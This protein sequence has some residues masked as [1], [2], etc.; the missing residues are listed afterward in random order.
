M[1]CIL[2]SQSWVVLVPRCHVN[3]TCPR[4]CLQQLKSMLKGCMRRGCCSS[5]G[6]AGSS[7]AWESAAC[8][9]IV[10]KL[11]AS[12]PSYPCEHLTEQSK[13]R[14]S[15]LLRVMGDDLYGISTQQHQ[16]LTQIDEIVNDSLEDVLH[17]FF[18]VSLCSISPC[19]SH[20]HGPFGPILELYQSSI[21]LSSPFPFSL[22]LCI[23]LT[24]LSYST[25]L[26]TWFSQAGPPFPFSQTQEEFISASSS[27]KAVNSI[28]LSLE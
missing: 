21:F 3:L 12:Q 14:K 4:G 15:H 7:F 18:P 20:V 1:A 8:I 23:Y 22:C 17:P 13:E 27:S 26:L 28:D 25:A 5:C 2:K 19:N 24:G 9:G 11:L 16:F 10:I 6:S